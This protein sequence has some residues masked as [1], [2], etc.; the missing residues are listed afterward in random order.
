MRMEVSKMPLNCNVVR[1]MPGW[2]SGE[3]ALQ[4]PYPAGWCH[5]PAASTAASSPGEGVVP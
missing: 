3:L 5:W 4:H 2:P 1:G